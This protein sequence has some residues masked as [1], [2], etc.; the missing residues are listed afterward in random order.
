MGTEGPLDSGEPNI[1]PI[2]LAG[3]E[4]FCISSF[5]FLRLPPF[6][7][8]S[9]LSLAI[10]DADFGP[11]VGVF[12]ELFLRGNPFLI[13]PS[14]RSTMHPSFSSFMGGGFPFFTVPPDFPFFSASSCRFFSRA[15]RLSS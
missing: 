14:S 12:F 6:S 5:A 3:L 9:L 1:S 13:S 2:H 15:L 11:H 8:F 4:R 10:G 7:Q